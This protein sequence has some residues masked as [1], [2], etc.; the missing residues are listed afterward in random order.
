MIAKIPILSL[1][2]QLGDVLSHRN[3]LAA[4]GSQTLLFRGRETATGNTY[5][6]AGYPIKCVL[7]LVDFN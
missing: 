3:R 7:I 6:F 4:P 2:T 1:R 5:A